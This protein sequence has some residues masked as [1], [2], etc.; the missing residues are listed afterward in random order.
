MTPEALLTLIEY[1]KVKRAPDIARIVMWDFHKKMQNDELLPYEKD[2]L[3]LFMKHV[4][5]EILVNN[6]SPKSALGLTS[7]QG[8][9]RTDNM[10]RDY[11]AAACITLLK[12]QGQT[13]Q[14]AVGDAANLFFPDGE[15]TR[16]VED[17]YSKYRDEFS[18][19]PNKTLEGILAPL[20]L[21]HQ[22]G[23]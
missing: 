9:L 8:G 16:A 14:N 20:T 2:L 19:L 5:S 11:R 1:I 22:P 4:F 15:G 7:I 12:R 21:P 23:R 17:A 6:K 10:A 13:W 18:E 3:C